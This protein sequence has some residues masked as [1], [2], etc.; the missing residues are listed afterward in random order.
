M[1]WQTCPPSSPWYR[2]RL[3]LIV[4]IALLAVGSLQIGY[5]LVAQA[6]SPVEQGYRDYAYGSSCN[7]TPTG[8]KP[9]SK[10]WFNDGIW[11]GSLCNPSANEY[12]I[13]RLDLTSQSWVDTGTVLDDRAASK[14]DALWDQA[15]GKLYV[16]SHLYT[17][18]GQP[19]SSSSQW[20]RL[21]RYSYHS[22]SKSYSLDPGFPVTVTRGKSETLV[23]AKDSTG[24]L[25]VTYVENSK[26]MVN[27]STGDDLTWSDPFVLPVTSTAVS[28]SSDDI[29]AVVAFQGDK[30]GVMWSNQVRS[31]MYFAVHLDQ[32]VDNIWQPEQTA[33]P[34]PNDCSGACADDHI[35]LKSLQVDSSGRVF[36]A[37][38]TSLSASSAPLIMLL[39]RNLN[40]GW[41]SHVFGRKSDSHTRPI[42]LLDEEHNRIYMFATSPESGGAIYYK[43]TDINNINFPLGQG[44]PFIQSSTD[45]NI[46]N[47]TST[48][49]NVTSATGL[50]VLASDKNSGYYLHNYISL[51]GGNSPVITSF[52]P[53]SG[54][55]G[56]EVTLTGSKFTGATAVAFNG[57]AASS[58]TV[59]S[60]TQIRAIVPTGATSGP[61]SVT[62]PAGTGTSASAF[63]VTT[64]GQYTLTVNVV[65]SGSVSLDP[66]GGSYDP[67]TTVTLTATPA[68]GFVFSGW[69]GDLSGTQNPATLTMDANKSVTAT[70]TSSGGGGGAVV[71]EETQ[72]GGA[73]SLTT[74]TTA[75]NLT[76]ASG[77][78]YLA[79]I[80]TKPNVEVTGVSGLGLNWS[81]VRVQCSGRNQTMV[82]LWMAQGTPT[83]DSPVS[84][85]LSTA[86]NSAVIA[87]SRYSGVSTTSPLGAIAAANT[88]GSTG[89][90]SGGTDS[91]TYSVDLTTTT[92]GSVVYGAAAQRFRS[93]T[94][95]PGYTE[96]ADLQQGSG[97]SAA[98]IAIEDTTV[99][100]P[101]TLPVDGSFSGT[102]D[103]AVIAVEI[104]P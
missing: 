9:E 19:T 73:S 20:G 79:A 35:N 89:P 41:T 60:D 48:K 57:T 36:A 58:Y 77:Q 22:A 28:V 51:G 8:E 23:L 53:T 88:N 75:A 32:D 90:C 27:R 102:V 42:V 96:R 86:N 43:T 82:A 65:G 69:S 87:V 10:L 6:S 17:T 50:V 101:S 47:A 5:P 29:S 30:V 104:R 37:I 93:H 70:F 56:T 67:G 91:A 84:A 68:G 14:A 3:W 12:H 92:T 49:Q 83:G 63:T 39:V 71:H 61:I 1:N 31:K 103:W 64:T 100:S 95:G 59:D 99:A 66:P 54:P 85:T 74:V 4:A 80:S 81:P 46:N 11:W 52:T 62:T 40:G 13:Y 15:T 2:R 55:V 7:S 72:T 26:V 45:L 97:G 38:K 44:D 76:A 21:Y 94:P 34:G 78:L 18:N 25:W 98:G 16:V 33:L 24:Q